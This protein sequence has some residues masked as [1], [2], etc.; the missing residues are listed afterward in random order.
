[1]L[2]ELPYAPGLLNQA[3]ASIRQ[4][5]YAAFDIHCLYRHDQ[6]QIIIWATI[7]STTP[8]II[9]ALLNDPRTG[10]STTASTP[11]ADLLQT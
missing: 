2:D 3:P 8:D 4:A 9:Q 6:G 7:T 5:T 10:T 1:L 11:P